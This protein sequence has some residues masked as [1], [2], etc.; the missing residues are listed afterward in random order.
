[1]TEKESLKL[2]NSINF[3][4]KDKDNALCEFLV[5]HLKEN[6]MLTDKSV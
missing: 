2:I 1:M 6:L 4:L 3:D 5:S